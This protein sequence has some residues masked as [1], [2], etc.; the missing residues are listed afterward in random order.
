MNTKL[1][2]AICLILLILQSCKKDPVASPT[3]TYSNG[4]FI[5]NEGKYPGPG[6]VSFYS[7]DSSKISNSIFESANAGAVLGSVVQSISVW[8]GLGYVVENNSARITIVT[9]SDFKYVD[10]IGSNI[11]SS[12]RYFMG[13]TATKAYITDWGANSLSGV[14][15]V[16]DLSQKKVTKKIPVGL[17]ADRMT[18]VNQTM[19]VANEGGYGTDSVIITVN[20]QTDVSSS[21]IKVGINPNSIQADANGDIWV[22]CGGTYTSSTSGSLVC[23]HNGILHKSY[24]VPQGSKSLQI[25]ATRQKLFFVGGTNVYSMGIADSATAVVNIPGLVL[26]SPYGAGLDPKTSY[27]YV[28]DAKDFASNGSL[29]ILDLVNK[30]IVNTA[31]VGVAP[32]NFYFE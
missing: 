30:K 17:G 15:L 25:D 19:Y 29:Y 12:P 16:Y 20:T 24:P 27:L 11:L 7:R 4:V 32:G 1:L 14:V 9:P 31:T 3:G 23:L 26:V 22:L 5:T 21:P 2:T 6:T 8:N 18:L 28:S 13:V 10:T